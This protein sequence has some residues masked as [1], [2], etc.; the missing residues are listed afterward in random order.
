MPELPFPPDLDQLRRQARELLRA[1]AQGEPDSL[2]RLH[3]VSDRVVLSA[4]Q[5]AVAREH[6]FWSWPALK[7]TVEHDRSIDLTAKPPL[8]AAVSP[9]FLEPPEERWSFGGAAAINRA[10]LREWPALM[11]RSISALWC[12]PAAG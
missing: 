9:G 6:G 5:L 2:A 4:A 10:A 12:A 8:P 11:R 3:A 1:A 7:A